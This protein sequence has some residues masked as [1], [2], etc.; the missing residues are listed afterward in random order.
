MMSDQRSGAT[1][2]LDGSFLRE[3]F[4]QEPAEGFEEFFR[5]YEERVNA[6][7]ATGLKKAVQLLFEQLNAFVDK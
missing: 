7:I 1:A 2:S 4:N 6:K 5:R 3:V